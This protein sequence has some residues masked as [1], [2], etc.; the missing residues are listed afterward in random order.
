M[1]G[2]DPVSPD[3]NPLLVFDR[4]SVTHQAT[5]DE[6][7][8]K[9]LDSISWAV[10]EGEHWGIFG[11]NGAGKSTLL[12]VALGQRWPDGQKG[13]TWYIDGT[14]ETSPLAA[15]PHMAVVSPEAQGEYVRRGWRLTG[16][17]VLLTAFSGTSLLYGTPTAAERK[18][19]QALVR[20]LADSLNIALLLQI[21][22]ATMSQGQL[23]RILL[24]RAILARPRFLVLDEYSDGLDAASSRE[25]H[26]L[27][28]KAAQETTLLIAAHRLDDL[29]SC[30]THA[31]VLEQGRVAAS[32]ETDELV[33]Q[34]I[35]SPHGGERSERNLTKKQE[36]GKHLASS[37]SRAQ[38]RKGRDAPAAAPVLELKNIDLFLDGTLVLKSINWTVREGENW[39]ISG[40]NG[41]GKTSLLR[42]LWGEEHYSWGGDLRWFGKSGPFFMPD[43]RRQI[44]LV[45]DRLQ[46]LYHPDLKGRDI[47]LSGFFGSVGLY[48]AP[49]EEMV[50]R[51]QKCMERLGI[52]QYAGQAAGH[53][54]FGRLRRFLLCRAIVHE[55]RLLLLDEPC[56]GLD[57]DARVSFLA[58]LD[59][60]AAEGTQLV[61]ITH[62]ESE[63]LSAITHHLR[64]HEG[65]VQYCG[66]FC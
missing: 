57:R 24:A 42:M 12:R 52:A 22:V 60:L 56:S 49:G 31:L 26:H 41:A 65:R 19:M 11:H 25:L 14:P 37:P 64:L 59:A 16:E 54:S 34:K 4:V 17:E 15:K 47:V 53:M 36:S 6:P 55:P 45:S 29:P 23:R 38:V 66:A 51:A 46:A 40:E 58:L 62:R 1:P 13:V 3:G 20:D 50:E 35:L 27:L 44:G 8:L 2:S 63:H 30:V 28:E 32:G 18:A 7:C 39:L 43:L 33:R 10:R 21:P 5:E 61:Y 48:E 9:A